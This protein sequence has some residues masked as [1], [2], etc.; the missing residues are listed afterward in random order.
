MLRV[1][2]GIKREPGRNEGYRRVGHEAR[3]RVHVH[4]PVRSPR[5]RC[6][7]YVA[8]G[9]EVGEL[10]PRNSLTL[11]VYTRTDSVS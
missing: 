11:S 2:I 5:V 4:R 9:Y 1:F 3:P 8:F 7:W 6:A 10:L